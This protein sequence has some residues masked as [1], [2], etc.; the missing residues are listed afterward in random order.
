MHASWKHIIA[1]FIVT[2]VF[3]YVVF[4]VATLRK[5]VVGA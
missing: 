1:S 4:H 5:V 3:M 2:A